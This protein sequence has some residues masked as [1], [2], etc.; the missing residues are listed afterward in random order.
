MRPSDKGWARHRRFY[1]NRLLF[2]ASHHALFGLGIGTIWRVGMLRILLGA[3]T[4]AYCHRS[5]VRGLR[6]QIFQCARLGSQIARLTNRSLITQSSSV[7]PSC[8]WKISAMST[9]A[10]DSVTF[11]YVPKNACTSM[12]A[13]L[14][15]CRYDNRHRNSATI[16]EQ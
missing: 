6:R 9:T 4:S 11:L 7:R 13:M 14:A 1:R 2:L 10:V 15:P 3:G 5:F 12:C 8:I 16:A